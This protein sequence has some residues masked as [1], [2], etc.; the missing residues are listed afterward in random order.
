MLSIL[1]VPVGQLYVFFSIFS[2]IFSLFSSSI[3]FLIGL[4]F[5]F[6]LSCMSCLYVES[7]KKTVQMNLI[8]RA[9][10]EMQTQRKDE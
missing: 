3:H 6:I 10:I 9:E 7:K 1:H 2:S 5:F 4:L 8:C